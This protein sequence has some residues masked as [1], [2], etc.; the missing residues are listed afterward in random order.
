MTDDEPG[1]PTSP[2]DSECL[3]PYPS[4]EAFVRATLAPLLPAELRWLLDCLDLERV[5]HAMT[6]GGRDHLRLEGGRVYLDRLDPP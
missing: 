1:L 3:G 4:L 5:L 2:P 6:A